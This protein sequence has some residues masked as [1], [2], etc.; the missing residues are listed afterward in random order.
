HGTHGAGAATGSHAARGSHTSHDSHTSQV[1]PSARPARRLARV[2]IVTPTREL[3][4][5]NHEVICALAAGTKIRSATIYG[6][7][8]AGQ[9]L[10][11][12]REGVEILVACPGRLLDHIEQGHCSL[13]GIEILVLDEADRMFD[14]GF[15]PSIKRILKHVPAHRQTMLFSATF[16]EEIEHLAAQALRDPKRVAIGLSRPAHTVAHA[17]FPVA[18]HLKT[19]L[20][21]ALLK[22]TSTESVLIFTRTRRRAQRLSEQIEREG[23]KTTSLHSDRS[24][25]Q[26]QAALRGFK[27]GHYQIMVATDIAA[28]G[29]DVESISHVINYDMPGS[30]DD[31]IHRIGRTGRAERTGDAFTLVTPED[32]DLVRALERIM[33]Q[34]LPREV[35]PGFDYKAPA[36]E[37]HA[38]PA[39]AGDR[40]SFDRHA[41][42]ARHT[43][44]AR[45]AQPVRH[46]QPSRYAPST[47]HA[48]PSAKPAPARHAQPASHPAR[49]ESAPH[50][51]KQEPAPHPA[52]HAQTDYA[53]VK[54]G[55]A[56]P[57]PA[58]HEP[59]PHAARHAQTTH[60][61]AKHAHAKSE[62]AHHPDKAA[63]TKHTKTPS[64]SAHT[65][66]HVTQ[67]KAKYVSGDEPLQAPKF[68]IH[69]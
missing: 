55:H 9:Q 43:Q 58:K 41:Q 42:P 26:R 54:S 2:L 48:Q 67:V 10:R 35:L 18:A 6:G 57:H 1:V 56:A 4:E 46:A 49:H 59:A 66:A 25:V 3:A 40:F 53:S 15:L 23:Y 45:H 12:L 24:Q 30:P 14:M 28:R 36:P 8:G 13:A 29:L 47:G 65:P 38:A 19:A 5:Q 51:A 21:L 22:Q 69:K 32:A 63:S 20:M 68:S 60:A 37:K 44:P 31:Y 16:P 62:P 11:A 39:R 27:S 52:R 17:L 7:V 34:R 61:P 50:A 64:S 33:G